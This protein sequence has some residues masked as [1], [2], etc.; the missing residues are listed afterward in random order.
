MSNKIFFTPGP[1]QLFYTFQDHLRTALKND[2]PSISHRGKEFMQIFQE[3][4]EHLKNLFGLSEEHHIYFTGSANEIWE[5]IIQNLIL[6]RSHHFVNGAFARKFYNFALKYHKEPSITESANGQ[7]FESLNVPEDSELIAIT[8]N[9]T[10]N[11][12]MFTQDDLALLR[13]QHPEKLIAVD[14]VSALPS[15]PLD[16]DMTDTAFLSVQKCFGMPAGLGV[17]IANDRCLEKAAKLE[18]DRLSIGSYHSLTALQKFA[19]KNQTPETPNILSIYILGKIAEDMLR[20]GLTYVRNETV[21]KATILYQK[22]EDHQSLT[23]FIEDKKHRSKTVIVA[24][25]SRGSESY[26]RSCEVKG[27][28]LGTGYGEQASKQLRIANFPMHSKEVVE[29]LCD[30]IASQ[31]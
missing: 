12:F 9:E 26:I 22:I 14:G 24:Q 5:R 27:W 10:S 18:K 1:T 3:T 21:Y 4:R 17:W 7:A 8:L 11:G 20:R 16:F 30:F 23:P 13:K 25:T 19:D 29:Q 2:I 15:I 6:K 28:V 31:E